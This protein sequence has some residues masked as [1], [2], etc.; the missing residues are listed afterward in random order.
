MTRPAS[1]IVRFATALLMTISVIRGAHAFDLPLSLNLTN[2]APPPQPIAVIVPPDAPTQAFPG[3]IYIPVEIQSTDGGPINPE[4]LSVQY[5]FTL[6]DADNNVKIAETPVPVQFE[7]TPNPAKLRG[8]A[9][10]SISEFRNVRPG[11]VIRYNFRVT[12]N[13]IP[14]SALNE[15]TFVKKMRFRVT[16]SGAQ[17]VLPSLNYVTGQTTLSF[18]PNSLSGEGFVEVEQDPADI[19]RSGPNGK[20]AALGTLYKVSL[21]GVSLQGP[22]DLKFAAPVEINGNVVDENATITDLVP[23]WLEKNPVTGQVYG[24]RRVGRPNVDS[25]M[26]TVEVQ[27]TK[28]GVFALFATGPVQASDLRPMERVITPNGDGINDIAQFIGLNSD[29]EVKIFDIRGRR[30]KSLRGPDPSWNGTEENGRIAE[31]GVYIYQYTSN[32]ERTSGVIVI[33][34]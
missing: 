5:V 28:T 26:R 7:V 10:V 6:Y 4:G 34:K 15:V 29:D 9:V 13:G 31:S 14:P 11:D 20:I 2:L 27:T 30:V 12:S 21:E 32:G 19:S 3:F 33:A 23:Y 1:K 18:R 22:V 24:W 8:T 25:A 17:V 16:P